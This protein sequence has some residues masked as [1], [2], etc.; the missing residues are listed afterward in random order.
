MVKNEYYNKQ[1]TEAI[2]DSKKTWKVIN[3]CLGQGSTNKH[4]PDSI[5]CNNEKITDEMQYLTLLIY[6]YFTRIGSKPHNL[7]KR[8]VTNTAN[9]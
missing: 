2:G 7:I 8:Q 6:N 5:Q 3:N 9:I 1:F 4:L